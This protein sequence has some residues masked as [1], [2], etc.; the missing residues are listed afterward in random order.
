VNTALKQT[1]GFNLIQG[2]SVPS[3]TEQ[4]REK[5]EQ[6][7]QKRVRSDGMAQFT[8]MESLDDPYTTPV[9]REPLTDSVDV[10]VIGGGIGGLSAAVELARAGVPRIRIIDRAGGFGG[11]WY[12]NRYPG[13]QC[14]IESYT[15]MPWLEEVGHVPTEKYAHQPEILEHLGRVAQQFGLGELACFHTEVEQ[16]EWDERND[17]WNIRTDRG[18]RMQARFVVVAGGFLQ[19]P[20][21]PAIAGIEDFE[22]HVFHT[23]RW[24]YQYTGGH[25]G[26]DGGGLPR[27]ADQRVGIV[28]TG[29]TGLQVVPNVAA[30]AKETFVFQRT[31]AV[32]LPRGNRPTDPEW[33]E[34]L[35]PGWQ[36]KRM[37]AFTKMA[38]GMTLDEDPIDDGWTHYFGPM[39]AKYGA[40]WRGG[41]TLPVAEAFDLSVMDSVRERI[42]EIVTRDG[43]ADAL[44]PYYQFLCKR[45]GFHDR[46][47]PAFNRD[48][49]TL[50]DTEGRGID[51]I[52]P[53]GVVA[54]GREYELDCLIL[55]TGFDTGRGLLKST[56]LEVL[57]RAGR[58]LADHWSQGMRSMHGAMSAGFPNCFFLGLTQ[59]GNT[60]SFTH[61]LNE[62]GK[63]IA[64]IIE[65]V[66]GRGAATVEA[67]S[68][69]EDDW[70]QTILAP[71]SGSGRAAFMRGCTP[72]YLNNEGAVDDPNRFTGRG[73]PGGPLAYFDLLRQWREEA[74]LPGT[75]VG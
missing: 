7:R 25:P 29:A 16:L 4:I 28:G 27:L 48:N 46:Y 75:V 53:H 55:A 74:T 31:P 45:P 54:G 6:E 71:G 8:Y 39:S 72:S 5:Y 64:Y 23:S 9:P 56:G 10:A 15:Y 40:A 62:Q 73:Y 2:V 30:A 61:G 13:A 70:T 51:K 59:A 52:T 49:V 57:G 21:L 44:K 43:V 14:D 41:G 36:A 35:E 65:A 17:L 11:T 69:A 42:G 63:H 20:K 33:A 22:G 58:S 37:L 24:D 38:L 67:T 34:S 68:S 66:R 60:V 26:P 18:D 12:W 47:L 19:R 50:V 1:F 32:V 3:D